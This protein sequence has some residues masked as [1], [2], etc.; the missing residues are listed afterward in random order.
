M[1][2]IEQQ[3]REVNQMAL[4]A[5]RFKARRGV[6]IF[7]VLLSTL[8]PIS[9]VLDVVFHSSYLV[10]AGIVAAC[11]AIW[12]VSRAL[13]FQGFSRMAYSIDLLNGREQVRQNLFGL[14]RFGLLR[15][16]F[17]FWPWIA[18]LI[19]EVRGV[20]PVIGMAFPLTWITEL[21]I[22]RAFSHSR[23]NTSG[24]LEYRSEDWVVLVSLIAAPILAVMPGLPRLGFLFA[25]IVWLIAGVKSLNDAPNEL[26]L[27]PEGY[28]S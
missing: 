12:F 14:D 28:E 6:G 1:E 16:A 15:F 2:S 23:V 27:E 8:I 21:V 17:F 3:R 19:A 5:F 26:A 22:Y 24:I 18:L 25:S 10:I 9:V 11:S 7:Y 4:R 13:G 20:S